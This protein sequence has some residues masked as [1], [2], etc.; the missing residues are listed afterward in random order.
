M[1]DEDRL[2]RWLASLEAPPVLVGSRGHDAAVLTAGGGRRVLCVDATV[3]GIHARPGTAPSHLGRKAAARALSDLAATA[4]RPAA[5]RL[6]LRAPRERSTA[7]MRAA[8]VGVR[9]E[10]ARHG[11]PLVGGDLTCAPGSA[12]FTVSALGTLAGRRAPVGRD[13]AR[14]GDLVILSGA[15]G[16]SALGRHLRLRPR[17][18]L[19]AALHAAGARAM[20]DVSDGLAL[21]LWRVARASGVRI[22]LDRVPL[23]RDARRAARLD[24][25]SALWHGLHDG[26]DHELVATMSRTAWARARLPQTSVIA[27]VRRG[28][29]LFLS[30]A[31]LGEDGRLWSPLEGGYRHG[32]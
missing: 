25:R 11:A 20:M 28:T 27:T 22:V 26:E 17:L 4:A 7:W 23:H 13:R 8:I 3:E 6:A 9:R 19:G 21:D 32:A 1:W 15:V 16:G 29:G 10:G 24:G 18:A 30:G 31:L 5:W 14:V 2:H 12:S